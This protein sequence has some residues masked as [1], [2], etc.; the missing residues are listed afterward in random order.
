MDNRKKPHS[1]K[2]EIDELKKKAVSEFRDKGIS[3]PARGFLERAS[4]FGPEGEQRKVSPPEAE[5]DRNSGR[6]TRERLR[7]ILSGEAAGERKAGSGA[8]DHSK[9]RREVPG[10]VTPSASGTFYRIAGGP[11]GLHG[12]EE[13]RY[14]EILRGTGGDI[15]HSDLEKL[16]DRPP[17]NV[18]YL[19]IETTGLNSSPL[20]LVGMLYR[21]EQRFVVDQLFARDYGEEK[22]LLEFLS[23]YLERF[24]AIVTFNGR[25]FDVPY[26]ADR[27]TVLGVNR[28][29][30]DEHVDLLPVAR[31]LVGRKTPDHKLQTLEKYLLGSKRIDDT[32]GYRIPELYHDY[33]RNGDPAEIAGIIEHNR[34]DLISMVRLVMLFLS[35]PLP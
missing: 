14:S 22:P 1:L 34:I 11:S 24:G 19:D 5:S 27:M 31:R 17:D 35:G 13:R 21:T 16:K 25:S 6:I 4:R 30:L 8:A 33:V 7:D 15:Q 18:C 29:R 9:L 26:I 2:R 20:F 32:P 12:V 28:P 10:E 3:E 23:P